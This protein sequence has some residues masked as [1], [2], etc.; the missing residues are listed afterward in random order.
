[1]KRVGIN[2]P[3][4]VQSEHEQTR[5]RI[6]DELL[7]TNEHEVEKMINYQTRTNTNNHFFEKR[8]TRTNTIRARIQLLNIARKNEHERS[9][10]FIPEIQGPE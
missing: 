10:T 7:D 3:E 9:F 8:R 4:H 5:T 6:S 2:E 1:M